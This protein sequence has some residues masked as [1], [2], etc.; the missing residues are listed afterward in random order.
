MKKPLLLLSALAFLFHSLYAQ[1]DAQYSMYR[2][3]GLYI[4]PAY[5][6]SHDALNAMAIYRHQ[7]TKMPGLP[8]SA[9]VAI[10]SPLKNERIALGLIYSFDKIG[11]TQTNTINAHFAYRVPV[12][13]KKKVKLCFG[14][15]AG[16]A[17]Y[18]AKLSNVNVVDAGDPNFETNVTNRWLPNVGFGIYAYSDRFFA[19]ISVPHILAN[20]LNGNYSVFYTGTDAARQYH[21]LLVTGGY[22]FSIGRKVKFMPSVLFKYVPVKTPFSF[23][24]NIAFIFIDRVWLG[25]G[26][27]FND[28][29]NFML[30]VNITPQLRVGYCYD[31]TV[32][33]LNKYTSG[34]HEIMLSYD[35]L[36]TRANIISPRYVKYF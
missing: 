2:F 10:H 12:G 3:N 32:T 4:N 25:A 17:H 22:V 14:L 27:R 31:L 36:F 21:H 8:Q 34:S 29:Y 9:S 24:F 20:K 23:D 16:V 7:W 33:S 26:Y 18:Q 19:G 5:A 30:A 11:V 1:Q 6:G 35:A 28:S 15:S 13:K